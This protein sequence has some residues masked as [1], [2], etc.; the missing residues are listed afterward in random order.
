MTTDLK[1]SSGARRSEEHHITSVLLAFN[2]TTAEP[3]VT[4]GVR[5][6]DRKAFNFCSC[7]LVLL[8]AQVEANLKFL[9]LERLTET[10]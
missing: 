8:R 1:E 2:E 7:R 3:L 5:N 9:E 10:Q 4:D 6:P